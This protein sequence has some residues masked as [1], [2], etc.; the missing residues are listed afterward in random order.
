MAI[1]RCPGCT[2]R[3]SSLA[4]ICPHCGLQLGELSQDER[5]K[6]VRRRWR[7]RLYRARNLTFIAMGLVMLGA[8]LWWFSPPEGLVLPPPGTAI[9]LMGIGVIAYFAGW[10]W[11]FWLRLPSNRPRG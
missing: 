11:I 8:I 2:K 5:D 10:F 7:T 4:N 3:V 9:G 6:F 1:I